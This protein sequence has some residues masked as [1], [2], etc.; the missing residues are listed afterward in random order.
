MAC[1]PLS[2]A[3]QGGPQWLGFAQPPPRHAWIHPTP[4]HPPT[5]LPTNSSWGLIPHLCSDSSRTTVPNGCKIHNTTHGQAFN[6]DMR[7]AAPAP[8]RQN[9]SDTMT[10]RHLGSR[11]AT[12]QLSPNTQCVGSPGYRP[13]LQQPSHLA[14]L[15]SLHQ[16][17]HS[18]SSTARRGG[19]A[20][21]AVGARRDPTRGERWLQWGNRGTS[22]SQLLAAPDMLNWVRLQH[23]PLRQNVATRMSPLGCLLPPSLALRLSHIGS[24]RVHA[25]KRQQ[26]ASFA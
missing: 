9:Y 25:G 22:P 2:R 8:G 10:P 15:A 26:S 20:P 24:S 16:H 23:Q 13:L 12:Y 17:R 14:L 18:R 7:W 6:A 11:Q 21:R 19:S 3:K 5:N 4:T 1:C